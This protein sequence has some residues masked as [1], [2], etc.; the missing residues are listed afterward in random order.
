MFS[1]KKNLI[2][3]LKGRKE[4]IHGLFVFFPLKLYFLDENYNI[5]EKGELKPFGFY[6]PKVKAKWLVEVS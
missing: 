5:L 3:D 1:K 2:F 6:L 4:L